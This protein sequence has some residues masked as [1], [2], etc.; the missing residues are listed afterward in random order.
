MNDGSDCPGKDL[1]IGGAN[2]TVRETGFVDETNQENYPELGE[3]RIGVSLQYV[4]R[5]P[6]F[7]A[8]VAYNGSTWFLLNESNDAN[9]NQQVFYYRGMGN[10]YNNNNAFWLRTGIGVKKFVHPYDTH[11]N[12][13]MGRIRRKA[14]PAIRYVEILL[15]YAEALN[16]LDG[17]HNIE[18]WD[19]SKTYAI[20]RDINEMKK[21]FVLS[22]AVLVFRTIQL[23][24][25][26]VKICS[27]KKLN[28][29][30]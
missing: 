27:G 17:S 20:K 5:E 18:S 8:S 22:V 12:R 3:H 7:Y 13:D 26:Q 11:E 24:N 1:E 14:E 25:M 6:R 28:G 30:V 16:E 21:V 9:R 15:I 29:N 4:Q 10:G 19:G 23:P 2:G